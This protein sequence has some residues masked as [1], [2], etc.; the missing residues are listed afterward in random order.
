V[1]GEYP[2]AIRRLQR[3]IRLAERQGVLGARIFDTPFQ[4]RIDLRIGG[5]AF[6]C[7][8]ET[9]LIA[10]IE[11][12]RGQPHQRPPYPAQAGLWGKPTLINNVETFA[13]IAP[14]VTNGGAWYA[15]YGTDKSRGTKVFALAGKVKNT[16]RI[17]VPLGITVREVVRERQAAPR[18]GLAGR[19]LGLP[20]VVPR[21]ARS[22]KP[23][24]RVGRR[25]ASRRILVE[26]MKEPIQPQRATF[27]QTRAGW[28]GL[29]PG[30][31]EGG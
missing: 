14:I 28:Q 1:R 10:S 29:R 25:R 9:A 15:S 27:G 18:H 12:G 3:A 19:L 30:G 31:V 5:G 21:P 7:C 26:V 16:G 22:R 8:E 20:H 4:F 11:G 13:N 23:P 17:E 6:V 24:A 2:I